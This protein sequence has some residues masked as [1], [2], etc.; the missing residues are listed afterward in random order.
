MERCMFRAGLQSSGVI[1]LGHLW[2][3]GGFVDICGRP[4]HP[5]HSFPASAHNGSG[6]NM[7]GCQVP[8]EAPVLLNDDP[9]A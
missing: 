3:G 2:E 7:D 5:F 4:A 6:G 1:K 9:A 8:Y